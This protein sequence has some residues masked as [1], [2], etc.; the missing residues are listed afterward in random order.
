MGGSAL[1]VSRHDPLL[2]IPVFDP[3]TPDLMG[4]K[5]LELDSALSGFLRLFLPQHF[6]AAIDKEDRVQVTS[7]LADFM[8][9]QSVGSRPSAWG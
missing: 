8:S 3:D 5:M 9:D 4:W 6:I 7:F 2:K 1:G